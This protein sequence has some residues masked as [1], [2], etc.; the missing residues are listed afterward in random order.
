MTGGSG[1]TIPRNAIWAIATS[2]ALF[3][4]LTAM[5]RAAKDCGDGLCGSI[6]GGIVIV[7]L[8]VATLFFTLRGLMRGEAPRWWFA[9]PAAIWLLILPKLFF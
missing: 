2:L 3:V 4:V 5:D 1:W 7:A 9:V 6:A 8:V